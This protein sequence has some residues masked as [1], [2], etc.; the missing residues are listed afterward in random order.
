MPTVGLGPLLSLLV[1]L[2]LMPLGGPAGE[3]A[4]THPAAAHPAA[5]TRHRVMWLNAWADHHTRPGGD[6]AWG[7][8]SPA[9]MRIVVRRLQRQRADLGVLAEVE[10]PQWRAFRAYAGRA[11]GL[12]TNGNRT[13]DVVFWRRSAFRLVGVRRFTT[14][15]RGGRRIHTPVVTLADR[16]DG[17]RVAVIPVHQP[18][19][20]PGRPRQARWR[21]RDL[22]ILRRV[23]AR[24]RVPVVVA[25]DFNARRGPLCRMT[26][27]GPGLVSPLASHSRCRRALPPIDQAF[28]TSGLRPEG[29]AVTSGA[30]VRRATDHGHLYRVAIT[31][32]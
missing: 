23:V 1:T 8:D 32:G 30:A 5:A 14:Y 21:A 20:L 15:Y 26:R 29:Y 18:A 10:R 27:P 11:L 2:A 6:E 3:A 12:V 24:L 19:D 31:L 25:G 7:L 28:V 17:R 22:T 16:G 13:D 9:R 4:G